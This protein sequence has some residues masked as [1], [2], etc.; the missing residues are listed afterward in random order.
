MGDVGVGFRVV[1]GFFI[2]F[3]KG[4]DGDNLFKLIWESNV[5]FWWVEGWYELIVGLEYDFLCWGRLFLV[6]RLC[7]CYFFRFVF[8]D[9]MGGIGLVGG[10]V[11]WVL[12]KGFRVCFNEGCGDCG[13]VK[14]GNIGFEVGFL[15][16][17]CEERVCEVIVIFEFCFFSKGEWGCFSWGES[18]VCFDIFFFKRILFV[19]MESKFLL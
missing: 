19:L 13:L 16:G 18:G 7:N 8:F 12:W 6:V 10:E 1:W 4:E 15:V 2:V 17:G 14:F 9:M 5:D 3:C 11:G